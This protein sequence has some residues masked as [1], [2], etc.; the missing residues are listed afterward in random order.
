MAV[1][2][3]GVS[4]WP[5]SAPKSLSG[6]GEP[7][8]IPLSQVPFDDARPVDVTVT[9]T[10][11]STFRAPVGGRVTAI[12]CSP[13]TEVASGASFLSIDGA[14]ILS[15]ATSVPLWR[16]LSTGDAGPDVRA[17]Q[18]E[19][20]R[21]GYRLRIDGQIGGETQDA[22]Q[23]AK[24]AVGVPRL[25][26]IKMADVLWLPG[27]S[28]HIESCETELG[29][30]LNAGDPVAK[31][32]SDAAVLQVSSLPENVVAGPRVVRI[33]TA[34]IDVDSAGRSVSPL[35][36]ISD[37]PSSDSASPAETASPKKVSGSFA[38]AEPVYVGSLP[39]SAVFGLRGDQG[40]VSSSGRRIPITVVG[41]QLGQTFVTF[42]GSEPPPT[43]ELHPRVTSTC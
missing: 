40:C 4:L 36:E 23:R 17:L 33:G 21:L 19:L 42:R 22:F 6:A 29:A 37:E 18:T 41:S 12:N 1:G 5:E 9:R 16:D 2:S 28:V 32:R 7:R 25:D 27:A 31:S 3:L 20:T 14:P 10:S 35:P 43:V 11:G 13:G 24:M 8:D 30:T 15:L 34:A 39:P 26:G 38:L